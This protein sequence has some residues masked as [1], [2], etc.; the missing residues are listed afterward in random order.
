M[1]AE[2]LIPDSA[3]EA[4]EAYGD[5]SGLTVI[6]GGTIV[7]QLINYHRMN[8]EK[9]LLLSNAGLSYVKNGEG[10]TVTIGATTPL[11]DL[12]GLAAPLG[13]CAANVADREIRNT[14]TLGG[15]LCSPTPPDHPSGDLQSALI[16][17]D[18]QVRSVGG[19]G[20]KS[21]SVEDFL[22]HRSD[23]LVLDVSFQDPAKGAFA[24]Y[25]RTHSHHFTPLAVSG[26]RSSS[27]VIRLAATGAGPTAVRLSSA[28][29]AQ[30]AADA[31]QAA[32]SDVEMSDDALISAWYREQ[33]FPGMVEQVF[34]EVDGE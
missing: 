16:A 32:L 1:S 14:A 17:L 21:E 4:I 33:I 29:G 13:P 6:A 18:A 20:E 15:N 27:G 19:D 24:A 22:P 23:R 10:S 11:A 31:G 34:A 25:R 28:E 8:P 12:T 2:L 7:M 26:A 9:V 3:E 5:G 30:S